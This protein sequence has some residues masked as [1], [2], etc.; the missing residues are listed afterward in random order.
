MPPDTSEVAATSLVSESKITCAFICNTVKCYKQPSSTLYI[1][2]PKQRR[3]FRLV[4]VYI[5]QHMG[6]MPGRLLTS[7]KPSLV[8]DCA[9]PSISSLILAITAQV[10]R[11]ARGISCA[12]P[13]EPDVRHIGVCWF[14]LGTLCPAKLWHCEGH[15]PKPCTRC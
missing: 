14:S 13:L 1:R 10:L 7:K 2:V 3:V 15:P 8:T 9:Y 6:S 4:M 11:C 12:H 5:G